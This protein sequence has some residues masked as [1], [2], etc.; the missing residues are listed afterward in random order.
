MVWTCDRIVWACDRMVWTCDSIVWACDRIVWA[1]DRIVWACDRIVWACVTT[2]LYNSLPCH[3]TIVAKTLN[4]FLFFFA[5]NYQSEMFET[6]HDNLCNNLH[7][8]SLNSFSL[9]VYFDVTELY[10]GILKG[11]DWAMEEVSASPRRL[12]NYN[13]ATYKLNICQFWWPCQCALTRP[14]T[15]AFSDSSGLLKHHEHFSLSQNMV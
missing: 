12:P 10:F 11:T 13:F 14:S 4:V 2:G 5:I 15:S 1:C 6:F 9:N 3:P 7:P 8:P